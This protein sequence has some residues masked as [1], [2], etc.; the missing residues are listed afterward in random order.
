M[1]RIVPVILVTITLLVC[2]VSSLYAASVKSFSK[3]GVSFNY[4]DGSRVAEET[5]YGHYERIHCT[6]ATGNFFSITLYEDR[7]T[8]SL[9]LEAY[10]AEFE[11]QFTA[12]G[13]KEI[14]FIDIEETI[15]SKRVKGFLMTF[16]LDHMTFEALNFCFI[17]NDRPVSVTKQYFTFNKKKS[18][19]FFDCILSSLSVK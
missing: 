13:A 9:L 16:T 2:A 18:Q 5:S 11:Q 7:T 3:F 19:K 17:H 15:L 12:K 14:A 8:A 6:S 10:R 4:P 1:K